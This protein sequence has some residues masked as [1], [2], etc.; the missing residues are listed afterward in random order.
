MGEAGQEGTSLQLPNLI[1]HILP[2]SQQFPV[3]L[4]LGIIFSDRRLYHYQCWSPFHSWCRALFTTGASHYNVLIL[5]ISLSSH[6][7][8][9]Y[10]MSPFLC[11]LSMF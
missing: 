10:S 4:K 2:V 8:T 5:H 6:I 3:L 1:P 9:A 7:P 11:L